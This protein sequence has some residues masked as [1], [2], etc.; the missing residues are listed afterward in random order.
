MEGFRRASES[1]S[2]TAHYTGY[3]WVA[4]GLS[5]PAFATNEGRLLYHAL[6]PA[7]LAA[8]AVGGPSLEGL[9]VARHR[10]IDHLLEAAIRSEKVG[11]VLEIACGLSPRGWR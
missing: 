10:V 9:L 2:P 7:N 4:N 5:H 11:Q 8:R 3:V 1:I 6:R